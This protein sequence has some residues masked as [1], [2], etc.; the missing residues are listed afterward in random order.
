MLTLGEIK[1]DVHNQLWNERTDIACVEEIQIK[2]HLVI[3]IFW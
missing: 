1:C 2:N 3:Q